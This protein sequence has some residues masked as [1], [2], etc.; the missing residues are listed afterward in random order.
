MSAFKLFFVS[1]FVVGKGKRETI[2]KKEWAEKDDLECDAVSS[3][4]SVSA[5]FSF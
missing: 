1:V 5:V 2:N 3:A 4:V